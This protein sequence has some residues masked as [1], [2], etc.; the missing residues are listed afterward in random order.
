M[1][2]MHPPSLTLYHLYCCCSCY[3]MNIYLV[4]SAFTFISRI[5]LMTSSERGCSPGC[6]EGM[7]WH[8]L[9][10]R[11]EIKLD[12]GHPSLQLPAIRQS[13]FIPGRN[14]NQLLP[15]HFV[16]ISQN[17]REKTTSVK[18]KKERKCSKRATGK[19]SMKTHFP[20]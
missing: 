20:Q 8:G 4:T 9:A 13:F 1:Y 17:D 7:N 18:Q 15:K 2:V 3:C 5:N 16:Q 14:P 6:T 11:C 19:C 12:D 10:T